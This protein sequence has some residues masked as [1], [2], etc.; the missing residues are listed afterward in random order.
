MP[1]RELGAPCSPLADQSPCHGQLWGWTER[2]RVLLSLPRTPTSDPFPLWPR[3]IGEGPRPDSQGLGGLTPLPLA[4]SPPSASPSTCSVPALATLCG[5]CH[6]PGP[7]PGRG[8]EAALLRHLLPHPA[9]HPLHVHQPLP[10]HLHHL[11]HLP[12]RG[13]HVAGTLQPA[14]GECQSWPPMGAE[15]SWGEALSRTCPGTGWGRIGVAQ[16]GPVP[17]ELSAWEDR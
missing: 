14:D 17:R 13:H 7:T 12:Q 9:A 11:R 16:A 3:G 4:S 10:G 1:G 2:I 15:V 6:T 8:P 5:L